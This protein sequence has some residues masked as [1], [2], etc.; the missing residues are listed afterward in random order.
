VLS[1][2]WDLGIWQADMTQEELGLY[3]I[4][5]AMHSVSSHE[6]AQDEAHFVKVESAWGG[7]CLSREP[8]SLQAACVDDLAM[9]RD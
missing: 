1:P 8:G 5:F 2:G 7:W 4:A 9:M 6:F 3:M